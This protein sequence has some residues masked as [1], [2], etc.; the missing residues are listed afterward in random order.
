MAAGGFQVPFFLVLGDLLSCAQ[1]DEFQLLPGAAGEYLPL[2]EHQDDRRLPLPAG[3][4]FS[5]GSQA[6]RMWRLP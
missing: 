6:A 5:A 4:A 2:T 1:A 3:H